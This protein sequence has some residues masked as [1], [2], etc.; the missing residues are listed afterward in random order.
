MT[1]KIT[2]SV[3]A[4][5]AVTATTY[6]TGAAIPTI[7]VDAQGRI[8]AAS[9]TTVGIST[10]QVTSGTLA[11]A[12]LPD[13][14]S[15][16]AANYYGDAAKTV[17]IVTDAKGRIKSASNV[18][19]Q[20]ATSQ[21]TG[22]PTFVASAT[23]DT[24]NAGNISSGTLPDARLSSAG[25]NTGTFGSASVVPVV[26]VDAKGRVTAA[27]NATIAIASSAVSGLATSAT[28]DTTSA[29]NISSGTLNAA[30]L[31]DSG[32]TATTYGNASNVSKVTV[33]AK[34]RVTAA[35][36]V[37][38]AIAAGSVSGLATV[39]TS[40]SYLDLSNRP[41]IPAAQVNSDWTAA[42]GVA[43]ILNKP[44]L[45]TVATSGSYADLSNKPTIPTNTNQLTNGA[46][47]V[48]SAGAAAAVPEFTGVGAILRLYNKIIDGGVT[49]SGRGLPA[50]S[51]AGSNLFYVAN[52]N[53]WE[54]SDEDDGNRLNRRDLNSGY[55]VYMYYD[56][57]S[58][59][60]T[61]GGGNWTADEKLGP[62][63]ASMS[64]TWKSLEITKYGQFNGRE[65]IYYLSLYQRIS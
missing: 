58:L 6:G 65:T 40:G 27:A 23:T 46:G 20:I 43:Q 57:M 16:T 10:S 17:A 63:I 42:S 8:T 5:T 7:T 2:P 39:A 31:A 49:V 59:Y 60:K 53:G 24:T 45:A 36:N 56:R 55:V 50:Q 14:G 61:T 37:A 4:N 9:N 35:S 30:R 29:T 33:D 48:T 34:G 15:L 64:G 12:R 26:T 41:T 28:T 32:V 62:Y 44:T 21:I 19:I 11:D 51:F 38:I 1:T 25:T 3:L 47:F 52:Y 18:A 54:I 13:Q 22:Y